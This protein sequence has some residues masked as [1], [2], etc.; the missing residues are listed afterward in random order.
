MGIINKKQKIFL[1]F[2]IFFLL[3]VFLYNP[4]TKVTKSNI[5]SDFNSVKQVAINDA[6]FSVVVVADDF[7]RMKGLSGVE[8]LSSDQGML[9]VFEY[10]GI[11]PFWMKDML[12]PID[13]IWINEDFKIVY[14]EVNLNPNTYPKSFGPK[15]ETSRFVLEVSAGIVN[16]FDIKIGDT[17]YFLN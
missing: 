4:N 17:V 5:I 6:I 7:S 8:Y 16:M 9:F 15:Q 10:S 11:Y 14:I 12:I 1:I 13:I 2:V 3:F